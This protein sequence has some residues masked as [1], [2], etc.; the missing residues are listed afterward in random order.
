[1]KL[2][3][4][5]GDLAIK[6]KS[7]PNDMIP[8][9]TILICIK[10]QKIKHSETSVIFDAW[11]VEYHGVEIKEN[12]NLWVC[13]DENLIPICDQLGEDETLTW[14]PVPHKGMV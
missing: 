11:S 1:M 8:T 10:Y 4:K 5:P 12:G 6:I 14:A 7:D 13:R 2:N 9:G 3:C